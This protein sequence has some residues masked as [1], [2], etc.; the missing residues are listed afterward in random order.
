MSRLEARWP[1]MAAL[2]R[3]GRGLAIDD[4]GTGYSSLSHLSTLPIDSLK[5][6]RSFVSACRDGANEVEV[7]RA[8]VLLG[9]SLGKAVV[10]EGIETEAQR[11]PLGQGY[12]LARPAPAKHVSLQGCEHLLRQ[13][14]GAHACTATRWPGVAAALTMTAFRTRRSDGPCP[15]SGG[16]REPVPRR[17]GGIAREP[18]VGLR[19]HAAL[20][21]DYNRR[22]AALWWCVVLLGACAA[23]LERGRR[24][25]A[26]TLGLA[27]DRGGFWR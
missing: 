17:V 19:A 26:F 3:A 27:A 14:P 12:L 21:P 6:D 8:I 11:Q 20:M 25:R 4:F 16:L 24:R 13:A 7:A 9:A 22:A 2:R 15:A 10:A 5:I 18:L 1:V 23:G